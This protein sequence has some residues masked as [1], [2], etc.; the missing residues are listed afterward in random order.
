[1]AGLRSEGV[2][3]RGVK[4]AFALA[5]SAALSS[6][7][8][9]TSRSGAGTPTAGAGGSGT[10]GGAV[11]NGARPAGGNA[12][13]GGTH[14]GGTQAGSAHTGGMQSSAGKGTAGDAT[15]G[16]AGAAGGEGPA[17]GGA[18]LE[19]GWPCGEQRC[20]VGQS[21]IRCTIQ[22]HTVQRC[23]PNADQ[24]ATGFANANADC[25]YPVYAREDCDGPEDCAAGQYCVGRQST[26]CEAAPAT[27][28]FCCFYCNAIAECT[29]CHTTQDCAPGETCEPNDAPGKG[30][31]RA[32]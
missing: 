30:C 27:R 29:L 12:S 10:G 2:V 3:S 18:G 25:E 15:M 9:G 24:D 26:R 16:G 28:P 22:D 13:V 32:Q 31:H 8:G 14:V 11:G 17:S 1:M 21:C 23:V 7:C 5:L 19:D 20:S 6:S 4:L